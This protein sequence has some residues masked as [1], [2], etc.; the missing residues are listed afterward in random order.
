MVAQNQPNILIDAIEIDNSSFEDLSQNVLES[1]FKHQIRFFKIDFFVFVSKKKYDLIF[2]NP[3][4]YDDGVQFEN[5]IKYHAKHNVNFS[6][7]NFFSRCADLLFENGE[8]WI[9]VPFDK[10]DLWIESAIEFHL[11][12]VQRIDIESKP[13]E[14]IRCI[15]IFSFTIKDEIE[16]TKFIVRDING[17]YTDE[18]VSLTSEFH[19][20]R[21]LK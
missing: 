19:S 18:Y 1:V 2:S 9:I 20:K 11:F 10:A 13:N 8:I 16:T 14:K 21:P 6:K 12:L 4:F 17:Y 3:P 7:I 5:E 15:L